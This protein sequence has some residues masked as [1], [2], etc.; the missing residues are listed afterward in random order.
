M[1]EKEEQLKKDF[2]ELMQ[3]K[4]REI[5]E[6][7]VKLDAKADS[8]ADAAKVKAKEKIEELKVERDRLKAKMKELSETSDAAWDE[9]KEGLDHSWDALKAGLKNAFSKFKEPKEESE[10]CNGDTE[11][12]TPK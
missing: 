11:P 4:F 6:E 12:P 9:F 1:G 3:E 2:I 8:A 7:L 10:E 5:D